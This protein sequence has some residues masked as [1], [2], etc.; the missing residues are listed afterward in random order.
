MMIYG[1][2]FTLIKMDVPA[3]IRWKEMG[4]YAHVTNKKNKK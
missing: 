3:M 1:Y 2:P 4:N